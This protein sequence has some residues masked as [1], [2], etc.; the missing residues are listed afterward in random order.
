MYVNGNCKEMYV[1]EELLKNTRKNGACKIKIII[2]RWKRETT[3]NCKENKY[4][5]A[6]PALL[7]S[8]KGSSAQ[9]RCPLAFLHFFCA[10]H[11]LKADIQHKA[12]Q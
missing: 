7:L 9:V 3:G 2:I 8:T 4:G 6:D 12:I 11:L 10:D 5:V 1:K